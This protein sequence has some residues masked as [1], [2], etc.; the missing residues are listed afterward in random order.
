M[1][2]KSLNE[3]GYGAGQ[4]LAGNSLP[5]QIDGGV[6][7]EIVGMGMAED[8]G[9]AARDTYFEEPRASEVRVAR[10]TKPPIRKKH[11]S[12]RW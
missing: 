2:R 9:I 10:Y 1:K 5:R 11:T 12:P 7:T 6:A 3:G 8:F 4:I